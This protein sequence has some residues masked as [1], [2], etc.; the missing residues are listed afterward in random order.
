L[1][2]EAINQDEKEQLSMMG[3]QSDEFQETSL[4]IAAQ[5]WLNKDV[6]LA[7]LNWKLDQ[8]TGKEKGRPCHF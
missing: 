2:G 5:G 8:L 3:A 6:L 1:L 4:E 7:M